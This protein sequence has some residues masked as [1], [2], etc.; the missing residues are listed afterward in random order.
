MFCIA[1]KS[2][3]LLQ[4]PSLIHNTV[5]HRDIL[6]VWFED[7]FWEQ[8]CTISRCYKMLNFQNIEKLIL[9][10]IHFNKAHSVPCKWGYLACHTKRLEQRVLP[11]QQHSTCPSVSYVMYISGA[12]FNKHCFN[13]SWNI[14]IQYFTVQLNLF[15]MSSLSSFACH[16]NLNVSKTGGR[17]GKPSDTG[18]CCI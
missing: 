18:S 5:C 11:W 6:A 15:M 4:S 12:K 17:E 9:L 2:G 3:I 13:I 16:K 7:H 8:N 10:H 1:N 14:F